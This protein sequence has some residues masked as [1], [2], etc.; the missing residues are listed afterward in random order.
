MK[1]YLYIAAG[2]L[3]VGLG[4]LGIFIPGLPTTPFLL[5]ASWLFYNSSKRLHDKLN[6]SI[7][8]K[9]IQ[10]YNSKSGVPLRTKILSI[11]CMWTMISISILFMLENLHTKILVAGLGMIGTCSIIFFVPSERKR[12]KKTVQKDKL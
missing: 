7:L 8:G 5:L 6:K 2:I 3:A 12:S 9:Y 11:A 4:T 10:R 1:K